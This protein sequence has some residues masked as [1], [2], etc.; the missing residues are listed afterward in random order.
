[1]FGG[2]KV[3]RRHVNTPYSAQ[4][5]STRRHQ[6]GLVE[7]GAKPRPLD[8]Q[9]WDGVVDSVGGT[10]LATAVAQLKYNGAVASTGVAG[11]GE[12]ATTVCTAWGPNASVTV[13]V[14]VAA[15]THHS[16]LPRHATLRTSS[17]IGDTPQPT[18]PSLSPPP[19]Q[20]RSSFAESVCS[21]WTVRY[22]GP[23]VGTTTSNRTIRA[24]Q[25]TG[26]RPPWPTAPSGYVSGML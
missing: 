21:A 19:L 15:V 12:L 13:A 25:M 24:L 10:T 16:L 17:V 11:G 20:I 3:G 7:E 1:M 4:P 2:A 22:L 6:P 9:R 23:F 14:A 18:S 5:H 26:R 8:K